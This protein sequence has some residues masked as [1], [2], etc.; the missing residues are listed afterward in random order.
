MC[1]G[2]KNILEVVPSSSWR[3]PK[4]VGFVHVDN[5]CDKFMLVNEEMT[6]SFLEDILSLRSR[7]SPMSLRES[8]MQIRNS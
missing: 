3:I 2:L 1:Y 7:K 5:F 8:G 6:A 4:P